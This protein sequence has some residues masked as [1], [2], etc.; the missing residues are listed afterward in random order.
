MTTDARTV[1]DPT[2]IEATQILLSQIGIT[3]ADLL[4]DTHAIPTF[5]D[6]IPKLRATL[7]PGTLRTYNTHLNNLENTWHDRQ[8]DAVS[9]ADLDE[10][11]RAVQATSSGGRGTRNGTSAREHFISTVRCLYRYAEDN[12]WIHPTRNPARHLAIPTRPPSHRQAIPS[13]LLAEICQV[14][15]LTG[16]DPELDTLLLRLHIETACRRSGAL[17]LRPRDLDPHQCL[18]LLREKEGIDRWQPVSPTLMRHLL[19]HAEQRGSP[20]HEQLLRYRNTK[21]ITTRRYDHLWTRIGEHLPWVATQHITTHWLRHTTLTWV[22]RTFGYALARA[23]A[24]HHTRK[25]HGTTA[26]YVKANLYEITAALTALTREP[27]PLLLTNQPNHAPSS[28]HQ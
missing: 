4:T 10:K 2:A 19:R 15:A 23:Y 22:E 28:T 12:N 8:L 7:T 25:T 26:T 5:G 21:P 16:N 1:A 18:I 13:P 17:H 6:V 9:K 20:P 3:A 27:H 24:G 11:A 14:A